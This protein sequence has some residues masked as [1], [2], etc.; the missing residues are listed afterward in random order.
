[1]STS[2]FERA[3]VHQYICDYLIMAHLFIDQSAYLSFKAA[4]DASAD[5]SGTASSAIVA[6]YDTMMAA[7]T[8]SGMVQELLLPPHV[9]GVHPANRGGKLMSAPA[10]MARGA[11]I[12]GVGMSKALCGP[13]KCVCMEDPPTSTATFDRMVKTHASNTHMFAAPSRMIRYGSLGGS[14]LNQFLTCVNAMTH[15]NEPILQKKSEPVIDK[16]RLFHADP[17]LA[18]ACTQGLRWSVIHHSMGTAFPYLADMV[19]K[20]LNTEHHIGSGETWEQVLFSCAVQAKLHTR[21]SH[22][23][24]NID[25]QAVS[26]VITKSQ[27]ACIADLQRESVNIDMK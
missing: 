14:H 26:K 10:M 17:V 6:H 18:E 11:R 5:T 24:L 3:S 1:M 9:V 2:R 13:S 25:W 19:Q 7:M 4:Y 22:G 21:T 12:F 15:T 23:K 20:A 16:D 8:K 27:P